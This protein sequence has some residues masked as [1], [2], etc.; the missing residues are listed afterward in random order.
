M[1]YALVLKLG[2]LLVAGGS[3]GR[4][5]RRGQEA[6]H[7][8]FGRGGVVGALVGGFE[9]LSSPGNDLSGL[10]DKLKPGSVA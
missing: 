7:A 5:R 9:R 6:G 10:P 1:A 4:G 8:A 3:Q 2:E